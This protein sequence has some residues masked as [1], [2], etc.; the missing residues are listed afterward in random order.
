MK[1]TVEVKKCKD[2]VEEFVSN[3]DPTEVPPD[4][5]YSLDDCIE[6]ATGLVEIWIVGDGTARAV[7]AIQ[8]P[9]AALLLEGEPRDGNYVVVEDYFDNHNTKYRGDGK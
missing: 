4:Q 9:D 7:H 2:Y 8:H 1:Q 5:E 6:M 3:Q